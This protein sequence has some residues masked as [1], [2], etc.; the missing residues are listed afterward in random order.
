[1]TVT[2]ERQFFSIAD[3]QNMDEAT[4]ASL[5]L[6]KNESES[7]FKSGTSF[8]GGKKFFSV[9]RKKFK[10]NQKKF[11]VIYLIDIT[12][13]IKYINLVSQQKML[14]IINAIVSHEMRQPLNSI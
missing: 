11:K 13:Q 10:L 1:M 5:V 9:K 2:H 3:F 8:S 14:Q 6:T 7:N 4:L 12:T